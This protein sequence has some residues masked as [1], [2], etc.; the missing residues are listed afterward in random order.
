MSH[1]EAGSQWLINTE[2]KKKFFKKI[3]GEGRHFNGSSEALLSKGAERSGPDLQAESEPP[4]NSMIHSE[5]SSLVA[6]A[7]APADG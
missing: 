6:T 2:E 3:K 4:V 7:T 5:L 1:G